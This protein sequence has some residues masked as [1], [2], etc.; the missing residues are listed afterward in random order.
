MKKKYENEEFLIYE[1]FLKKYNE[2]SFEYQSRVANVK[3]L[4]F[5]R[6]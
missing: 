2:E 1:N 5:S 3:S 6:H 4:E